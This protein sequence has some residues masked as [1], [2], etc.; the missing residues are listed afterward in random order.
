MRQMYFNWLLSHCTFEHAS[1]LPGIS[2]FRANLILRSWLLRWERLFANCFSRVV[3]L[4]AIVLFHIQFL[5][6]RLRESPLAGLLPFID[7]DYAFWHIGSW[8]N[9]FRSGC[10]IRQYARL[11][12]SPAAKTVLRSLFEIR[13]IWIVLMVSWFTS[14]IYRQLT[15]ESIRN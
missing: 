1:L 10:H 6:I 3:G 12:L 14:N 9:C 2:W 8:T 4:V 5:S 13:P 15:I 11:I 7:L